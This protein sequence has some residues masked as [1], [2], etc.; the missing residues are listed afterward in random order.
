MQEQEERGEVKEQSTKE[1]RKGKK[2]EFR[3]QARRIFLTFPRV[4]KEEGQEELIE[5]V[6]KK[7]KGKGLKYMIGTKEKHKDGGVHYHIVLKYEKKQNIRDEKCYDY[8]AGK[9]GDY[10]TVRD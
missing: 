2:G 7:E 10:R 6:V 9:H 4:E 1:E 3:L 8:I 5:K